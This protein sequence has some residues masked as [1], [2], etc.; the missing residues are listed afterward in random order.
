MEIEGYTPR[1]IPVED[2]EWYRLL[3][4]KEQEILN[5]TCVKVNYSAG[6]TVI[7]QGFTASHLL[8]LESGVVKLNVENRGRVTTFKVVSE[9]SF[10]GLICS[11]VDKKIDFSSVAVTDISVYL[12]S[13][14]VVERLI[15]LNGSFA[16]WIV[17][18]M[19]ELTNNIV[20][21][22]ITLSHKNVYG[23]IATSLLDLH[24]VFQTPIYTLPFNREEFANALGYSKESIINTLSEMK[25]DG[26][27]A[28]SGRKIEIKDMERLLL[29]A[30]NG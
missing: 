13:R 24:Q 20:H 15:E 1:Q 30:K 8:Y 28:I 12:M 11:F 6:E 3:L 2:T 22:L 17:K 23:A 14:E 10:V 21:N 25:R 29:I 4:P 19:S 7:K 16:L 26:I 27:I 9:G 5:S 18:L